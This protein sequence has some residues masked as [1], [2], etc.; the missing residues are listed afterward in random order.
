MISLSLGGLAL[1]VALAGCSSGPD[2]L[3]TLPPVTSAPTTAS[4]NPTPSPTPMP[5]STVVKPALAEER[6]YEGASEFPKYWYAVLAEAARTGDVSL[7]RQISDPSCKTCALYIGLIEEN[8]RLG[9]TIT[10][11]GQAVR[12]SAAVGGQDLNMPVVSVG[13]KSIPGTRTS[14]DGTEEP[15]QEAEGEVNFQLLWQG[16]SWVAARIITV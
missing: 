11:G 8:N 15:L 1:V 12:F 10:A 4:P 3:G 2:D 5:T 16:G 6:T 14:A 9:A 7:I 13:V